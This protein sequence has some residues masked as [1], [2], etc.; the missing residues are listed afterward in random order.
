MI[1]QKYLV[2][3]TMDLVTNPQDFFYLFLLVYGREGRF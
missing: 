1:K 3:V 2:G